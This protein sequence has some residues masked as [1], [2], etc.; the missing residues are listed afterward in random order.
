MAPLKALLFD[1]GG[2]LVLSP[3]QAIVDYEKENNISS[4]WINFAISRSS[5]NGHWQRLER[6]EIILDDDFFKGFSDDLHNANV[7]EDFQRKPKTGRKRLKDLANP[8]Q[9]GDP[10]SLKA[11]AADSEPTDEDR[12]AKSSTSPSGSESASK[13]SNPRPSRSLKELAKE[14][15]TQ[16]GDPVSLKAETANSE[17]TEHDRGASSPSSRADS[18]SRSGRPSK[19]QQPKKL[20]DLALKNPSQLGDPVSLKAETADSEPTDQDR[21]ASSKTRPSTARS[22]PFSID[23]PTLFWNMMTISRTPDPHIGPYLTHLAS[24][25]PRPFLLGALSNTITFPPSH[26]FAA[27]TSPSSPLRQVFDVF[28]ASAEVGMRKPHREIYELALKGLDRLDRERGGGG[29]APEEVL[30]L[31]DIAENVRMGAEVG[32]RTLRVRLGETEGAVRELER[33]TGVRR[34]DARGSKL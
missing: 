20:K 13:S 33:V 25:S 18:P 28:I 24:L 9:L 32:M 34:K 21:G 27:A 26:P 7:W 5:P 8:S 29:V 10:V 11:E 19:T 16:L 6:G 12:G 23:V 2:V 1:V 15:P 4:G 31:D 30:F 3:F 14:N 22:P 17:P